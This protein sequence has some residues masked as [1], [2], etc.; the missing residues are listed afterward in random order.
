MSGL[1]SGGIQL[2]R[3]EGIRENQGRRQMRN[4][5]TVMD[6]EDRSTLRQ[7]S[8]DGN[9]RKRSVPEREKEENK[10]TLICWSVV[11]IGIQWRADFTHV[12]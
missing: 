8:S 11:R 6:D 7:T 2:R 3:R 12:L 5:R 1:D 10:D 4:R 9:I